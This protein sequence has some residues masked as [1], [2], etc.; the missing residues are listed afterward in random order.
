MMFFLLKY[1]HSY[2]PRNRRTIRRGSIPGRADNRTLT[3]GISPVGKQ[4]TE[5]WDLTL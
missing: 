1:K 5:D 4:T 2:S 3:R